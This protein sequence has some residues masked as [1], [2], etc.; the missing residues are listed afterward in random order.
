ML[1]KFEMLNTIY[2]NCSLSAKEILVAQYFVY[3]SNTQGRCY[4]SVHTIADECSVSERTVQR[5]TKKLQEKGYIVIT[6]RMLHGKQ[7]SNEYKIIENPCVEELE[8][9]GAEI[10][11]EVQEIEDTVEMT[12]I[13]LEDILGVSSATGWEKNNIEANPFH[14]EDRDCIGEDIKG[15]DNIEVDDNN[16]LIVKGE[17]CPVEEIIGSIYMMDEE[18]PIQKP[19]DVRR[20]QNIHSLVLW[21]RLYILLINNVCM[22]NRMKYARSLVEISA[23]KIEVIIWIRALEGLETIFLNLGVPP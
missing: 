9:S 20:A 13:S 5:A 6:K 15:R 4:P 23:V 18:H 8:P 21:T 10:K 17:V 1:K 16:S 12:V 2:E 7:S 22:R 11:E 14:T 19:D 3:K